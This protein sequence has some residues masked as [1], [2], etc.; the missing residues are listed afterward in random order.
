M[1]E[2]ATELGV[3]KLETRVRLS[4]KYIYIL[5]GVATARKH[6]A[7]LNKY[8]LVKKQELEEKGEDSS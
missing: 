1:L 2:V 3:A 4:W 5:D 8:I 6:D 7:S